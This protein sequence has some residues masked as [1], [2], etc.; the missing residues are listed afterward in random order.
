MSRL[1]RFLFCGALIGTLAGCDSLLTVQD[2]SRFTDE[3]L[4]QAL[5]AVARGPEGQIHQTH[6]DRVN[7]LEILTDVMQ[8]TGTWIQWDDTD[9]GRI[10]YDNQ[11]RS[12]GGSGYLR[13]RYAAQDARA[14]FDR[15]RAEGETVS[16]MLYSQ[17]ESA[18][19]WANLLLAGHFCESVGD[20]VYP[21]WPDVNTIEHP[22]ALS[23]MEM[24]ALALQKL[25]S[26][27]ATAQAAGDTE[28]ELWV[29]AGRARANLMLQ[30]Y[31]AALADAQVVPDGWV[32]EAI[33]DQATM[34]NSIVS[35]ST[36][37]F[38]NASGI[39]EWM[40]PRV[41]AATNLLR[42]A[43]TDEP[44][45]R[46]PIYH[47]ITDGIPELGVDG[48]TLFYSQWKYQT[49]STNMPM[50][51]SEEMRLIEAEV[52]WQRGD[53]TEAVT[54][55]NGLRAA[56]GLSPV[57]A[58]TS[59]EVFELLLNERFAEL[60]MMG[61]R[62]EDLYRFGLNQRFMDEGRFAGT[63]AV[64]SVKFPLDDGEA[65]D[66]RNLEDD[67]SQRC[68]PMSNEPPPAPWG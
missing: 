36:V 41:D 3:D 51:H 2:P 23:D 18:E 29:R 44:D 26:A 47:R 63:E 4:N 67:N 13:A 12:D 62:N 15:L 31:D 43:Y 6:D 40:W 39:R 20:P 25:T 24:Y 19:A 37:G 8:H 52:Y 45:P 34:S 65:Q 5:E 38:N 57:T 14:R 42:D 21:D 55:L 58:T 49:E 11:G 54:I 64:R 66:N 1:G 59:N 46:I 32:Y 30:N 9:H 50:T 10:T 61:L 56:A 33:Y 27:L 7:N 22:Q 60:F 68:L 35:L 53:L 17:V 48:V 16:D 28:H